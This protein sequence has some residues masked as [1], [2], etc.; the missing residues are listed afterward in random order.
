M[1]RRKLEILII[2]FTLLL[3]GK[4]IYSKS[5]S[6][7]EKADKSWQ[8]D[9]KS[10]L[11]AKTGSYNLV[12]QNL[13]RVRNFL[14]E[15]RFRLHRATTNLIDLIDKGAFDDSPELLYTKL[16]N[17]IFY[18][19]SHDKISFYIENQTVPFL[20]EAKVSLSDVMA[21]RNLSREKHL[22]DFRAQA[23]KL[24][25][26]LFE[27]KKNT[28]ANVEAVKTYKKNMLSYQRTIN[29]V[30]FAVVVLVALVSFFAGRTK[31]KVIKK[32]G[33]IQWKVDDKF[34]DSLN[35]CGVI[36]LDGKGNVSRVNVTADEWLQGS[37]NEGKAWDDY[38]KTFFYQDTK[39]KTLKSFYRNRLF[40]Q[41]VFQLNF[42]THLKSKKEIIQIT[43]LEVNAL[44]KL[45]SQQGDPSFSQ[46][47]YHVFDE[48]I[49]KVIK[50]GAS[51]KFYPVFDHFKVAANSDFIFLNKFEANKVVGDYLGVVN[52]LLSSKDLLELKNIRVSRQGSQIFMTTHFKGESLTSRDFAYNKILKSKMEKFRESHKFILENIEVKN[53]FYESRNEVVLSCV[54]NDLESFA[55]RSE[56]KPK[57][58]SG[59][60]NA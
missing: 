7:V 55:R 47:T 45:A 5:I 36:E 22:K 54:I 56:R 26:E 50:N 48:Q 4:D 25:K 32:R 60:L 41:Y 35:N 14:L 31:A 2:F 49:D 1:L 27:A 53:V 29:F 30:W 37:V 38:V 59:E 42:G 58:L 3:G 43:R 52:G 19:K 34:S 8:K 15:K 17:L 12:K 10:F 18:L 23:L 51:S 57:A 33:R 9:R 40:P 16:D 46:L 21:T 20:E 6:E 28:L 13:V 39:L 11:E 24:E 44:A